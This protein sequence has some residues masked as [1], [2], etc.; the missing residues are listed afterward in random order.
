A[1]VR[2]SLGRRVGAVLVVA[3][4]VVA[5]AACGDDDDSGAS[6]ATAAS[7]GAA[8]SVPAGVTSTDKEDWALPKL[9]GDGQVRLADYRGTPVVVN[10]F[11]SWCEPCKREL[12]AF[13]AVSTALKGK[14]TFIGVNSNDGGH[15]LALAQSTGVTDWP[16]ARDQG[17]RS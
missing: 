16:L 15:G 17:G 4:L 6:G 3:L 1:T 10:L 9:T 14:V 11:A 8:A 5:A 2:R 12:P 13:H 7:G